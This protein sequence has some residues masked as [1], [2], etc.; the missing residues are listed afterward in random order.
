MTEDKTIVS[1]REIKKSLKNN[2]KY[3]NNSLEKEFK[4]DK[5]SSLIF[6]LKK[7]I[8]IMDQQNHHSDLNLDTKNK[9]LKISVTT[10]SKNSV[11]Q[12]DINF[13]DALEEAWL[14]QNL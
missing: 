11:T 6:F 7:T 12:A 14:E 5:F 4:F 9:I 3:I 1:K 10:H 8:K 2:W 13:A